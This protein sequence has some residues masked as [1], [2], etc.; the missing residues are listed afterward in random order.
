MPD[1]NLKIVEVLSTAKSIAVVG[2][3]DDWKRPS[4]YVMKYLQKQGYRIVPI[5]PRLAGKS[6]LGETVYK[7][8]SEVP[9]PIDIVDVFRPPKECLEIA[10]NAIAIGASCLWMQIGI[11][12]EEAASIAEAAGLAVIMN[13]CPKI[14][15]SRLSG[16]LGNGGFVSGLLSA[17]RQTVQNPPRPLRNGGYIESNNPETLA[18]H[19]GTRPDGATGARITPLYQTASFTFDDADHAAS[20]YDL[21]EPGNVYGRLSNPTTAALEQKIASLDGALGACCVASGHAAQLVALYPLMAPG[22]KIVASKQL[23]G[24]SITQFTQTFKNFGW[25][26]ELVDIHDLNAV[27]RAILKPEVAVL[28]AESLANPDGTITDI[29]ALSKLANGAQIPLLIDNT[30]ATSVMCKPGVFGADVVL[31]STTKFMSG[32]GNALGGAVVDTGSFDWMSARHSSLLTDPNPAYHGIRFAETFGKL[33]YIT[34]CHASVLR[35]LGPTMAPMNAFLTLTGIETLPLRMRQHNENAAKVAH[36]LRD[37]RAVADVSWA[38]FSDSPYY[39]RA[40]KYLA[41]G[42]GSV[43]TFVVKDGYYAGQKLVENCNLLSHLA[44]IGD[45]RSLIIHP[46]STTHRQ[47]TDTQREQAGIGAGTIRVSIGIENPNDIIADL[48]GALEVVSGKKF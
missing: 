32:H 25:E 35:D 8:I 24:G 43:F 39:E 19:A 21:Q 16:L 23:Y 34:F 14:E 17:R 40:K 28:F 36:F 2:A 26:A 1:D 6:I 45:T 37:H 15:H 29:E 46:A 20:L 33:S 3:S 38:G 5:N 9:Y 12:S 10:E 7:K 22:R 11:N 42:A 18:V 30:M 4:F 13:R 41:F 31:Y 27:E 48:D 44:N 47:L